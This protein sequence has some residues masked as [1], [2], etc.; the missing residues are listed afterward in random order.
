M[1]NS[2]T[3]EVCKRAG[4]PCIVVTIKHYLLAGIYFFKSMPEAK[5]FIECQKIR[6]NPFGQL[7]YNP[8]L[9]DRNY[10]KL[11]LEVLNNDNIVIGENGKTYTKNPSDD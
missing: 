9:T 8:T 2:Y 11:I 5:H 3:L 1:M 6:L 10:I 4:K 7:V